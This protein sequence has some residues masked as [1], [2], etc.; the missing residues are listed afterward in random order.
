[1]ARQDQ[2]QILQAIFDLETAVSRPHEHRGL[3]LRKVHSS[4]IW[5][6]RLG[7]NL[8]ALFRLANDE[9]IF[10][11]LGNHDEVQRFLRNAM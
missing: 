1:M 10:I 8:R 3:G 4:G 2:A 5:E 9:V 7:L 6:V 11:F